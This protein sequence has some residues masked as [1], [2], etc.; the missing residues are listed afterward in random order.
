MF[1]S[2][3]GPKLSVSG[4]RNAGDAE[5]VGRAD[6]PTRPGEARIA[7]ADALP[8][9]QSAAGRTVDALDLPAAQRA[10]VRKYFASLASLDRTNATV[11]TTTVPT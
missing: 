8:Q 3:V 10:L 11:A 1:G 9:Y 4:P 7:V 2:G 6:G 5:V